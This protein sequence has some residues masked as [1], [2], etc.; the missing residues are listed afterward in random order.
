VRS[1]RFGPQ[2]SGGSALQAPPRDDGARNWRFGC[3]QRLDLFNGIEF[4]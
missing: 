1:A 3:A 2:I 4:P